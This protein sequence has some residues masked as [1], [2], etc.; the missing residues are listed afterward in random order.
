MGYPPTAFH[1][2]AAPSRGNLGVSWSSREGL[3]LD[4]QKHPVF[5]LNVPQNCVH[6]PSEVLNPRNTWE[7]KQAYDKKAEELAA[8]FKDNFVK[9]EDYAN[10]EI[11]SGAPI[12][13]KKIT[14]HK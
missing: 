2:L 7:D 8:S 1:A 14:N 6:V 13:I 11:L 10:E 5:G 3:H 12:I 4:L 9:F